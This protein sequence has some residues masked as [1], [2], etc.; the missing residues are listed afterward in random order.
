VRRLEAA[1]LRHLNR[2]G[3]AADLAIIISDQRPSVRGVVDVRWISRIARDEF[4]IRGTEGELDLTP[5]NDGML[6]YPGGTEQIPCTRIC[7]IRASR[8]L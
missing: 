8:T 7:T 4:R 2:E 3:K 1:R 6:V 5:L